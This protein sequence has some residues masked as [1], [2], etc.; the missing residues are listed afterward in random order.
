M[1]GVVVH[2]KIVLVLS[3]AVPKTDQA[4][5]RPEREKVI[6]IHDFAFRFVCTM[7]GFIALYVSY[8]LVSSVSID[9]EFSSG[10]ALLLVL[11][12]LIGVI[13]VGGQLHHVI[14]FEK[15]P[16]SKSSAKSLEGG[17]SNADS[18]KS[19]EG[20]ESNADSKKNLDNG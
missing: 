15:W 2:E 19:L 9:S 16:F 7:A 12:F 20:G 11:L 1:L 17:E 14:L 18:K 8:S 10:A 5:D 4:L 13:G 6:D 3:V